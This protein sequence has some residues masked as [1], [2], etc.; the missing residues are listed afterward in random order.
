[1]N[2]FEGKVAFVTGA[3][4]GIGRATGVRLS[5]EGASVYLVDVAA[6]G[7]EETAKLCEELG[8][9]VVFSLCDVSNESEACCS[10][11]STRLRQSSFGGSSTSTSSELSCSRRRLC[12]IS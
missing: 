10:T 7:L 12:R 8:A 4:G 1:M 11:T 6:E 2:R 9:E 3:A 5:S